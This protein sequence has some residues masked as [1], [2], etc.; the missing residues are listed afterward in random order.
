MP[1]YKLIVFKVLRFMDYY[2]I[3]RL[4]RV[5]NLYLQSYTFYDYVT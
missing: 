1:Y 3:W 5:E 2:T 4:F